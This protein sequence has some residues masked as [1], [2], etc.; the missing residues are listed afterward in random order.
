MAILAVIKESMYRD[1]SVRPDQVL[2]AY[3]PSIENTSC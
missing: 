3:I 2:I 1:I